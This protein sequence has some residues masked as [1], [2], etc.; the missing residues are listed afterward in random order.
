MTA[1][2]GGH[3]RNAGAVPDPVS[4]YE[5]P[6][7]RPSFPWV[8]VMLVSLVL[9]IV[10]GGLSVGDFY[11]ND[12]R[13]DMGRIGSNL[14]QVRD[15]QRVMMGNFAEAQA[16]LLEQQR[17]LVAQA[18]DLRRREQAVY[19]A[20]I[21]INAQRAQLAQLAQ[22]LQAEAERRQK[23][24]GDGEHAEGVGA[25]SGSAAA[26][27]LEAADLAK[28]AAEGLSQDDDLEPPRSALALAAAVLM[29]LPSPAGDPGRAALA[30][31]QSRLTDIRPVDR[32]ALAQRLKAVQERAINLRPVVARLLRPTAGE[33]TERKGRLADPVRQAAQSL[34][35]QFEAAR[36]A[37]D[38]A[39][40]ASFGGAM[41]GIQRWLSA[42]Y[43]PRLPDTAAVL[44]ELR[45]LAET[46]VVAQVA[47]LSEA[48][49]ALAEVLRDSAARTGGL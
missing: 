1:T 36:L 6:M 11:W 46:P 23:T 45:A 18:Q 17:R 35:D 28:T 5:R 2:D 12:L 37:L 14:A 29:D 41:Q 19:E 43:E 48:L 4:P 13:P 15:R 39:D 34:N 16:L 40:S 47:P 24:A 8:S 22:T 10:I 31:A 30:D 26:R 38:V 33:R 27:L 9:V 32:T 44:A 42:F 21:E 7:W 49:A 3:V 25:V 20:R